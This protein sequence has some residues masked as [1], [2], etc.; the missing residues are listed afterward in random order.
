MT[1][2]FLKNKF[3]LTNLKGFPCLERSRVPNKFQD[4][5]RHY[6]TD[7]DSVVQH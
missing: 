5:Q 6:Y 3:M 1:L 2:P 7:T 4:R